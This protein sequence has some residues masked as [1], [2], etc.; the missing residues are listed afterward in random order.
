[1]APCP[2]ALLSPPPF[3]Y[4]ASSF[5]GFDYVSG[6]LVHLALYMHLW[7][8]SGSVSGYARSLKTAWQFCPPFV[9]CTGQV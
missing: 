5:L 2:P 9:L 6:F 7:A 4:V 8:W 1:M 3:S